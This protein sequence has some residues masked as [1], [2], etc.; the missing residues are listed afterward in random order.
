MTKLKSNIIAGCITLAIAVVGF[1]FLLPAITIHNPQLYLHIFLLSAVYVVAY[2]FFRRNAEPHVIMVTD[3]S[4]RISVKSLPKQFK[5]LIIIAAVC[6]G[7]FLIGSLTGAVIFNASRYQKLLSVGDGDFANEVDSISYDQIPTLDKD[8][9]IKLGDKKMGSLSDLVSQFSVMSEYY[10][11]INYK[12]KPVRVTPLEYVDVFKWMNNVSKG[13][14]GYIKIDMVSQDVTLVRFSDLGLENMKY[15]TAEHFGRNLYR[16]LRFNYP[17][18]MF[19]NPNFEIDDDGVPYWVCPRLK[20]KIGL[21]GGKDIA[22]VVLVN[23]ITGETKYYD[24]E[25]VPSWIDR[26]YNAELIM[27]QFDRHGMLKHGFLNSIFGQKDCQRTTEGYN[28]IALDDDVY[29]YTGVTSVTSD[30]SNIGF[31]LTNQRTK[32]TKFYEISGATEASAMG[33]AEGEVQNLR[34]VATFPLLLNINDQPTYFVALK[35]NSGLVR[36]YAMINV[37]KFQNVATGQTPKECEENYIKLIS[38]LEDKA[39]VEQEKISIEGTIVD[40][41]TAV[42]DGNTF[43]FIRVDADSRMFMMSVANNTE[44]VTYNIGDIVSIEYIE[45]TSN[46]VTAEKIFKSEVSNS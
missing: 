17:T 40:I 38:G 11:Q 24:I 2:T 27:E 45:A 13:V 43:Y 36:M 26:V 33:S 41:R 20:F 10:S 6:F 3:S 9:A 34:Y 37:S 31:I 28:Y 7:V 1:Y 5:I 8:S 16:H 35:D 25:K 39:P 46:V 42:I 29:M 32:E 4:K 12:G 15:S 22:G 19:E 21:F 14:P 23:A 44:I 18:Y 30:Q